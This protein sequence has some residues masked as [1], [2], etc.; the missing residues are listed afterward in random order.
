MMCT[1]YSVGGG[2][3]KDRK[4]SYIG[5]DE[6]VFEG[7]QVCGDCIVYE[8]EMVLHMNEKRTKEILVASKTNRQIM[9]LITE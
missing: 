1:R 5:M 4:V 3:R 2:R 6:I 9:S 7:P 8:A